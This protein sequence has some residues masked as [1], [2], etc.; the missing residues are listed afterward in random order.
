MIDAITI[1]EQTRILKSKAD[2][3]WVLQTQVHITLR[4]GRFAR[5]LISRVEDGFFVLQEVMEGE[6]ILTF[7][8]VKNIESRRVV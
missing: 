6:K 2:A 7:A 8:E 3:H 1:E 5:G 4:N